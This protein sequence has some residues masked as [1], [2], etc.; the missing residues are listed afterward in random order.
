MLPQRRLSFID[1]LLSVWWISWLGILCGFLYVGLSEVA[2]EFSR[3]IVSRLS[4]AILLA[5]PLSWI[6]FFLV[7]SK[8]KRRTSK[9]V[10]LLT[11]AGT[12]IA[13]FTLLGIW[14]FVANAGRVR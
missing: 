4:L 14:F 8:A 7:D 1:L 6:C 5:V 10:N 9:V 2:I 13:A 12:S 11:V 3:G